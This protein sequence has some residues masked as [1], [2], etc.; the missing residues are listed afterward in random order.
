MNSMVQASWAMVLGT[1]TGRTDVV[2]GATVS[3]RPPE[4]SDIESMVG[5]FINTLPVRIVLDPAETL[6]QYLDRVQAEQASLL[7]HHYLGLTDI[8]RA[9]GPAVA[10][11]TLTVFESY[12][13]DRAGLSAETDLAGMRVHDVHDGSDTA[14]YPLTLVAMVDDRLHIEAKYLPELFEHSVVVAT[15]DRIVRVLEAI[16]TDT[17]QRVASL[18]LLPRPSASCRTSS[19]MLLPATPVVRQCGAQVGH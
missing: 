3:G 13:M 14:Q 11:D 7:D 6:G 5:L 16:A 10:F 17:D 12:P 2:F 19:P 15:V 9:V 4:V 8:Q 1:L 18:S